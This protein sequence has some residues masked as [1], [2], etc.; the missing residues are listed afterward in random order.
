MKRGVSCPS[1]GSANLEGHRFC[2]SCGASLSVECPSCGADNPAAYSFC[3]SCGTRLKAAETQSAPAR[4]ER[5]VATVMFADMSGFTALAEAMDAEDVKTLGAHF[6]DQMGQEV[7]KFG[8]TLVSVMG[9]A[10]M[11]VFGAPIAHED[12]AERAV[13]CALSLQESISTPEYV[14]TPLKL[15][16][17]INTGEVMTG[18]VGTE[19]HREYAVMGDVTNTAARLQSAAK[20]GEIL[21]GRATFEATAKVIDYDAV[22]PV[23]AKGKSSPVLAW[24]PLGL[25]AAPAERAGARVALVGRD[26]ELN[27]LQRLW[28]Q[29][30]GTSAP[31]LVV[32]FGAPGIGKSRLLREF[33]SRVADEAR[34]LV[35]RSL[36][37]GEATGYDAFAEHVRTAT[38]V[39]AS[40]PASLAEQ[41][42]A[43][44]VATLLDTGAGDIASHLAILLGLSTEGAPD[45]GPLFTSARSFVEALGREQP[46]VLVFED[47]HWAPPSLISLLE[48]VAGRTRETGLLLLATARPDFLDARPSWGG[49]LPRY[50]SIQLDPLSDEDAR[51][52]VESHLSEDGGST[53]AVDRV[54]NAGGG[55]PLFLEEISASL[56]EHA[57]GLDAEMPAT[58]QAII[59]ARL[60]ALPDR[61]RRILQDASIIGRIFRRDALA[62]LSE[63]NGLDDALESLEFRDLIRRQP[64]LA[65][66]TQEFLFKHILTM[67]VAYRTLPRAE[68]RRRHATVAEHLETTAGDRIREEASL[69]A[70]HWIQA[71]Q[72]VRAVPHLLTAA[73][74]AS[75]TWA[76]ERAVALY[77]Q[78]IDILRELDEPAQL[79]DAVLER[80]RALIE[81]AEWG[82]LPEEDLNWLIDNSGGRTQALATQLAAT[83]AYWRGN[84]TAA[85]KFARDAAGRAHSV[86]DRAIESRAIA[87]LGDVAG[88]DGKL[89]EATS[90]SFRALNEWP[91]ANRDGNYA[92]TCGML[93]VMHYWRGEYEPALRWA[94]T[95]YELGVQLSS[96]T[97]SMNAGAQIG[98]ALTGLGRHE[99]ALDE[100]RRVVALGREW[101]PEPKLTARAA[102]ILAGTLRETGD[103]KA[104]RSS[105]LE[106]QEMARSASFPGPT[107]SAGIDLLIL[108]LL[109]GHL[110]AAERNLPALLAAAENTKGWH[111]WLFSGRLAE[112]R[113]RMELLSNRPDNAMTF[114]HDSLERALARGRLKYACRSRMV[115][116]DALLALGQNEKA[117]SVFAKAVGEAE[118]L[119][120]AL[121]LYPALVGL[122]RALESL[123]R[124]MEADE[125]RTRARTAVEGLSPQIKLA[126]FPV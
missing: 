38:G 65:G 96:L 41:K 103:L 14:G 97:A 48:S 34:V 116:G 80:A 112:A 117:A 86:S 11:A 53:E 94:E 12:D 21:V 43:D 39:V 15:H 123:G 113:A 105:S 76:K 17:G 119:G 83:L 115:L 72:K 98:L 29:A 77:T 73:E 46:T 51:R 44:R 7:A 54:V 70:H 84:A 26:A 122:A 37:Y 88:M 90:L 126:D 61:D 8:G 109:E 62:E 57:G 60:D 2:G 92:F 66:S 4:E 33:R 40:D 95:G 125:A 71:E 78:C 1:C 49:G 22:A 124:D 89:D 101:E 99:D 107:V 100:L 58:V 121:T 79:R 3:G 32:V 106:A 63:R 13:R 114:A 85:R 104:A 9:D 64:G 102:T 10:I 87:M 108:D 5:R 50:A 47:L 28:E 81:S 56:A 75:R 111:Q 68:R 110:G 52:L 42:I 93:A 16:I 67:E 91:V 30:V 23:D 19:L 18:L 69:I 25:R 45:K 6:S 55:N 82:S 20:A 35:G 59:A 24:M 27:L 118:R 74:A 120:H 31:H 36:P